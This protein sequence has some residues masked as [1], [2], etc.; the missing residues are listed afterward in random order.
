MS[1]KEAK[2]LAEQLWA[3]NK[4]LV[5]SK[6]HPYYLKIRDYLKRDDANVVGVERFIDKAI[7]LNESKKDIINAYQ[8][9][10]GYFKEDAGDQA[11]E[12]F[13]GLIEAYK[14]D[15][16]HKEEVLDFLKGL[17]EKYSNEYLENSTIFTKQS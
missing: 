2:R 8:H 5:L 10:W 13:L 1:N 3:R 14:N 15:K 11:K 17:L 9:I 4:Y 12:K 16:V 7:A 6:S